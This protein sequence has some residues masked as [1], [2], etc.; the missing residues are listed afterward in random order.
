MLPGETI[1]SGADPQCSECGIKPELDV[2]MSGAGYYIGT[3]CNC[4]P[5]SRE[6]YYFKTH[7][8]AKKALEGKDK[9]WVRR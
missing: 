5:Y 4:G 8:E 7:E 6:S 2:Y 3:Y 1:L 9:S